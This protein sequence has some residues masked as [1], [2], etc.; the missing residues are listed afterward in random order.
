MSYSRLSNVR[1]LLL[2]EGRREYRLHISQSPRGTLRSHPSKGNGKRGWHRWGISLRPTVLRD[3]HHGA[4]SGRYVLGVRLWYA[5]Y[6]SNSTTK[7]P[8]EYIHAISR[9]TLPHTES[10]HCAEALHP[11]S[12][13]SV[14]KR[15]L[16]ISV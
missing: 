8:E 10:E 4:S 5:M 16:C 6:S 9:C 15:L 2:A 12:V 14:T 7:I 11:H 3:M 1:I 13:G